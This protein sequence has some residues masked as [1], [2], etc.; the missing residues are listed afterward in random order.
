[1]IASIL[2]KT[3]NLLETFLFAHVD[4]HY[5][6]ILNFDVQQQYYIQYLT[7]LKQGTTLTTLHF[8]AQSLL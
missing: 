8:L 3:R 4:L 6:Q 7:Y 5:L 2:H 1:M